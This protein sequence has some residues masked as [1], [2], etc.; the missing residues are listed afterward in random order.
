MF[1]TICNSAAAGFAAALML[2]SLGLTSAQASSTHQPQAKA[3]VTIELSGG[4][5][6]GY[7]YYRPYYRHYGYGYYRPYYRHYG[8][9]RPYRYG[10]GYRRPYY[11]YGYGYAPRYRHYYYGY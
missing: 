6:Y 5:Y 7:G 11:G 2:S 4:G 10:Y 1:R 3:P 8:Y 9:Y